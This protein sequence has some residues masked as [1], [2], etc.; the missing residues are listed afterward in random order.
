[1]KQ[2]TPLNH[3]KIKLYPYTCEISMHTISVQYNLSKEI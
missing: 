1:M 2:Y 3:I